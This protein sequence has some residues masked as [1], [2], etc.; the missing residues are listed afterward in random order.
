MSVAN[1]RVAFRPWRGGTLIFQPD[2]NRAGTLG[3]VLTSDGTDRWLL[4]ALHVLAR[5]NGTIVATD[6]LFQPNAAAGVIATL[7]SAVGDA[8]LDCA[9]VPL[10]LPVSDEVLGLGSLTAAAA[11]VVGQRVMKSGWKT[12]VTEGRVESVVGTD[13]VIQRLAD[14]PS[15]YLLAAEGDSGA[16]WVDATTRAPVALHT[17]E[18]AVGPHRALGA[19]F[20]AVMPALGLRQT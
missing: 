4:T 9:A 14:Y 11:P 16:V 8:A 2:N 10:T 6:R 20:R 5:P 7:A 15:D 17:R 13:V 1:H 12:G 19:D 3:M 18:T